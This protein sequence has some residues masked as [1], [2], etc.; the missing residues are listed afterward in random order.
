MNCYSE[1]DPVVKAVDWF[2]TLSATRQQPLAGTHV[3]LDIDAREDGGKK[4]G[5][6]RFKDSRPL[7]HAEAVDTWDRLQVV[8]G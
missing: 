4:W 8:Q 1:V 7:H 3:R 2:V 5:V 6:L